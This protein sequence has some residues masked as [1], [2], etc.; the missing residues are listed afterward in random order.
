MAEVVAHLLERI[1]AEKQHGKAALR[2]RCKLAHAFLEVAPVREP[3]QLVVIRD[4]MEALLCEVTFPFPRSVQVVV[5]PAEARSQP[6]GL[7]DERH[8]HH[9]GRQDEKYLA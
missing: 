5:R 2:V 9:A 3:G 1:E 7:A 6:G 4:A 8:Q